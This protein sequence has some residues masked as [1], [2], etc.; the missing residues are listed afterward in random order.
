MENGLILASHPVRTLKIDPIAKSGAVVL[1][2]P[3]L[4]FLDKIAQ[5]FYNIF[6]HGQAFPSR[7]FF[8]APL[9]S[10]NLA[11][12]QVDLSYSPITNNH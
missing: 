2:G 5:V 10:G 6:R 8:C 9:L 12:L 1:P 4:Q 3:L 11:P 7:V